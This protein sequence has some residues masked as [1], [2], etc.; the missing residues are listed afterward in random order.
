MTD[1]RNNADEK[2]RDEL[3]E[4]RARIK[5]METSLLERGRLVESLME[6]EERFR[7]LFEAAP[8]GYYINDLRG[9]FLD[10][11]KAAED[12]IGHRKEELIGKS[13]LSLN[14]LSLG[15]IVRAAK[16][17]MK[18]ALGMRTGPD[19]FTLNRK[20]GSKVTAEISTIPVK[21]RG[22]TV[23]L[24][25]ARDVSYR[26][27]AEE[28]QQKL[29]SELHHAQKMQEVGRL[30]GEI[31][32]DFSNMITAIKCY[33]EL[34]LMRLSSREP[35]EH[36][37]D[38]LLSVTDKA[39]VLTRG[40][41]SFS[42]KQPSATTICDVDEIVGN[43]K[44]L[45][46]RVLGEDVSMHITLTGG[47]TTVLADAAQIEQ[48]LFNLAANA[49]DAM[50]TGGRI[51][52]STGLVDIDD[53]FIARWGFGDKGR[54]V[55]IA[56]S[57]TGQGMDEATRSRIFDP[58]FTTKEPG[59]GTGLGLAIVNGIIQ[60]HGG[61]ITVESEPGNGTTFAIYL[62]H[63]KSRPRP[64]ADEQ[65]EQDLRGGTETIMLVEDNEDIREPARDILKRFGY[66]VLEAADG[67]AALALLRSHAGPVELLVADLV[68]P[69]KNG[70]E[71][72]AEAK[73]IQPGISCLFISGHPA[74]LAAAMQTKGEGVDVLPKPF[75]LGDLLKKIRQMLD[76][77]G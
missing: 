66:T 43:T 32:H 74:H 15:D 67:Q 47:E 33:G 69:G 50:P 7:I 48:V 55:K 42:R 57:D 68:L 46:S 52:I 35:I 64:S 76:Q 26:V 4:C 1:N 54:F 23:I 31:A 60:E 25:I 75:S 18:N 22:K 65:E 53:E 40:L 70:T 45:L 38:H 11:N 44:K 13:F 28:E 49:R 72:F 73:K 56:V 71:V 24:G 21:L 62:P 9:V 2:G 41:L 59:K 27:R 77:R 36:Y 61:R 19:A 8:D 17:L 5:D 12:L 63:E 16:L 51:T 58:Y 20:D 29:L 14:L 39:A 37:L 6:G 34:A 30:S 10:G 3:A